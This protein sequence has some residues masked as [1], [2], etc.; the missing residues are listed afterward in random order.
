MAD[1]W[2]I[3]HGESQGNVDGTQSDTGLSQRGADQAGELASALASET[4]DLV[5]S[6]PLLRAKETAHLALPQATIV[7]EP[8]LRE[9][10]VPPEKFL[11]ISALGSAELKALL[12]QAPSNEDRP[13]SGL[14]FIARIR[15][16][17]ADLPGTG[18]IIAFSHFAVVR[19]C[20]RLLQPGPAPQS[21]AHCSVH[22]VRLP[23]PLAR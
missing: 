8:R 6:S 15:Q 9:L 21:I 16:W 13:E 20:L 10:V 2:L 18:R 4:F 1:L 14:E 19:E 3:R 5:L 23:V 17:L 11:D 22:A 7:V 12:A